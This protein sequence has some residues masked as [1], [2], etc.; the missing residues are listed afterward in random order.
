[1]VISD[2]ANNA[3]MICNE[4]GTCILRVQPPQIDRVYGICS[5][6]IEGIPHIS[7]KTGD[8]FD[9]GICL[10]TIK[11]YTYSHWY[12]DTGKP[13]YHFVDNHILCQANDTQIRQSKL[14]RLMKM[15]IGKYIRRPSFTYI[16]P[17]IFNIS[18]ISDD[19]Q[20]KSNLV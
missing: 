16:T 1:M 7:Y 18:G 6:S 2:K 15:Q 4:Q 5:L 8:E 19:C 13:L 12:Y 9:E 11:D 14:L 3:T 10:G 20:F 17:C